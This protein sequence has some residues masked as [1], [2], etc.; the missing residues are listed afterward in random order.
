[1]PLPPF[2]LSTRQTGHRTVRVV[3]VGGG[4]LLWGHDL[5]GR[6]KVKVNLFFACLASSSPTHNFL[7]DGI[8][9]SIFKFLFG[10]GSVAP[11][12]NFT[13]GWALQLVNWMNDFI[14]A[15]LFCFSW[16]CKCRRSLNKVCSCS[17]KNP[18]HSVVE[19]YNRSG[20]GI[21]S[22]IGSPGWA[23]SC[24]RRKRKFPQKKLL[25]VSLISPLSLHQGRI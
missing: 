15:R 1:M 10:V 21:T 16:P 22:R 9:S 6:P 12:S 19:V 8:L 20:G 14:P 18:P 4:W 17:K 25:F 23:T 7:R 3:V 13:T 11:W 5:E 24:C 2:L